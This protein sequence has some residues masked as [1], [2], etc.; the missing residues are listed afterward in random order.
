VVG[1]RTSNREYLNPAVQPNR[2]TALE[3]HAGF[4]PPISLAG[5][6]AYALLPLRQ[7]IV[8]SN[9]RRAF[10]HALS[11]AE[12]KRLAMA[13]YGHLARSLW[14]FFTLPLLR[15]RTLA[16]LVTVENAEVF[17]KALSVGRGLL[18]F[19]GHIGNWDI[20]LTAALLQYPQL[21]QRV[22]IF[23]RH[24]TPAWLERMVRHRFQQAGIGIIEKK[25]SMHTI[26]ERL[27][28]QEV[29]GFTMDQHAAPKEGV[30]VD[31]FGAPAWTFR[32]LAVIA[33]RTHA[34][35]VPAAMW[36]ETSGRHVFRLEE[37]LPPIITG[38][39]RED[40]RA[41]T[42]AYNHTLERMILRHPEQWIWNHRRWKNVEG[43]VPRGNPAGK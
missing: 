8:R 29:V 38:D 14:E 5:S 11:E 1:P 31:F 42:Q 40:I 2:A 27:A 18:M 23:V 41:N 19:G 12:T 37:P 25:N 15:Q 36:R 22:N 16:A 21:R 20:G 30:L 7:D 9:M 24:F 4:Q 17:F 26:I 33:L 32:S 13:F 10:G 43:R 34:P 3:P 6:I 35:V 28:A 39:F